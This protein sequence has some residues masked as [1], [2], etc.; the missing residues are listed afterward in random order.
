MVLACLVGAKTLVLEASANDDGLFQ[1][2]IVD[3]DVPGAW[4][5]LPRESRLVNDPRNCLKPFGDGETLPRRHD[6]V[7]HWRNTKK[8]VLADPL[9]NAPTLPCDL[10]HIPAERDMCLSK[11]NGTRGCFL[12]CSGQMSEAHSSI[13]VDQVYEWAGADAV[14]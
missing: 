13:F 14:L 12:A 7:R 9:E 11:M 5:A 4:R 6:V 1:R 10:V 3:Y 8:F 2:E